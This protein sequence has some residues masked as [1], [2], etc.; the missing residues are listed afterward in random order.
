MCK[1]IYNNSVSCQKRSDII[2]NK[3]IAPKGRKGVLQM[4]NSND[5]LDGLKKKMTF[6]DWTSYF[7]SIGEIPENTHFVDENG[8]S[9]KSAVYPEYKIK[10]IYL[11][12]NKGSREKRIW[13][14]CNK[15][16]R[17]RKVHFNNTDYEVVY[18]RDEEGK[19]VTCL[20]S[21]LVCSSFNGIPTDYRTLDVQHIDENKHNNDASN[22]EWTTRQVNSVTNE[23]RKKIS[24]AYHKRG[25]RQ[26]PVAEI[27][28]EGKIL[29]VWKSV[30]IAS[31]DTGIRRES[32]VP[33]CNGR[34]PKTH[35]RIFRWIAITEPV[36]E[37]PA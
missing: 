1:T 13:T 23:R 4:Q 34:F 32:I 28:N 30:K 7:I 27:S 25:Q 21:R 8:I 3:S 18:L 10:K 12:S 2:K 22:L 37:E 16:K 9:W 24:D 11:V 33:V 26:R 29:N 6:N 15:N 35:G 19:N 31:N 17:F 20:L 36:Y 14:L 5:G